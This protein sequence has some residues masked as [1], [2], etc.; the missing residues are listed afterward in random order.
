MGKKKKVLSVQKSIL[1]LFDQYPTQ[2]FTYKQI[3]SR[4][5][6]DDPSGRN[7]IIKRLK[8]LADNK[9]IEQHSQG[10]FKA[11]SQKKFHEGVLDLSSKGVGYII[12]EDFE[13]DLFV[14]SNQF[15]KAFSG[16]TVRFYV[17]PA[18]GKKRKEG[19]PRKV[20]VKP[21]NVQSRHT[22]SFFFLTTGSSGSN[23]VL[24]SLLL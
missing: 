11:K 7:H 20:D 15:H 6:V 10:S 13:D 24:Y 14:A 1:N 5:G 17:Y 22:R 2:T 8:K 9:L 21:R 4:L 18:R 3:G 19:K 16:D 12:S 23:T